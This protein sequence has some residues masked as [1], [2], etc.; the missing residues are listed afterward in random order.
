MTDV[1]FK[2]CTRGGFNGSA[3]ILNIP[4]AAKHMNLPLFYCPSFLINAYAS[5]NLMEVRD[6]LYLQMFS[7]LSHEIGHLLDPL[8]GMFTAPQNIKDTLSC[9]YKNYDGAEKL[10]P[11]SLGEIYADIYSAQAL[12]KELNSPQR[13]NL[14]QKEKL[15]IVKKSYYRLCGS[16]SDGVHPSGK[17]RMNQ[18]LLKDPEIFKI[19]NCKE[20]T[21]N[22]SV[23]SCNKGPPQ[24]LKL[25]FMLTPPT[26]ESK[27]T[28]F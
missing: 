27:F 9:I 8:S 22:H 6:E 24:V 10:S 5:D 3:S 11:R 20:H 19:F 25:N 12:S 28:T 13:S 26:R 16:K 21:K 18:I 17:F 1:F 14:S 15:H 4:S 2:K 23:I 7:I